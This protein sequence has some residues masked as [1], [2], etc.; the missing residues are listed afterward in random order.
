MQAAVILLVSNE[1][2]GV[3]IRISVCGLVVVIRNI[4]LSAFLI[5]SEHLY[6]PNR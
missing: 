3:I 4:A 2:A 5:L 6:I 1:C